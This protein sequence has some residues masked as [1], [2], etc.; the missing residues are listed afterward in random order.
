[1]ESKLLLN[2]EIKNNYIINNMSQ[3]ELICGCIGPKDMRI[4]K[5]K[6]KKKQKKKERTLLYL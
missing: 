5:I 2:K 6:I 1:M 3:V 4:K